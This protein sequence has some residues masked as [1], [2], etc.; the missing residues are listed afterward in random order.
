MQVIRMWTL[1]IITKATC[2]IIIIIIFSQIILILSHK[3]E[4]EINKIKTKRNE[5][6]CECE[7]VVEEREREKGLGA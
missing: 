4:R 7:R 3:G 1:D 2:T 5:G 6:A